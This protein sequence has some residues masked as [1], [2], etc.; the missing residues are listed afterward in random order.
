[1]LSSIQSLA[2]SFKEMG[3]RLGFAMDVWQIVTLLFTSMSFPEEFTNILA[4]FSVSR[5]SV[6]V[7]V[8][9]AEMDFVPM[10]VFVCVSEAEMEFVPM[11]V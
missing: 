10:S 9:E 5:M 11:S 8:S 7:C 6:F 4:R 1:V 2:V 3:Q